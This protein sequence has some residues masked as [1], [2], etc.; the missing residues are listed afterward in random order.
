MANSTPT[1]VVEKY[2]DA[3]KAGTG[4]VKLADLRSGDI[5]HL[6]CRASINNDVVDD[7]TAAM[8]GGPGQ[9]S[10]AEFPYVRIWLVNDELYLTSGEHRYRAAIAARKGAIGAEFKTGTYA[11]A[12]KDAVTSNSRHGLRPTRADIRRSLKMLFELTAFRKQSDNQLAK[13]VGCSPT[14]V[15]KLRAELATTDDGKRVGKDGKERDTSKIGRK[16]KADKQ[17]SKLDSCEDAPPLCC[18]CELR[19]AVDGS[20]CQQCIDTDRQPEDDE[21]GEPAYAGNLVPPEADEPED[22]SVA[23]RMRR[24][25]NAVEVAAR[26]LS[27]EFMA[28]L[29]DLKSAHLDDDRRHRITTGIGTI[30]MMLRAVKGA[31]VCPK[32]DGAG[33]A[34]CCEE[35]FVSKVAL[36]SLEGEK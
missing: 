21:T 2:A 25:N 14:T 22:L 32:C 34:F 30:C 16:P 6:Q 10:A 28:E 8:R 7:Y 19:D 1:S 4:E 20:R 33:C 9:G 5:K 11:D 35:G 29:K 13:L 3:I 15:G 27:V 18:A 23:E 12:L 24:W 17:L 31:A 26:T 36:A